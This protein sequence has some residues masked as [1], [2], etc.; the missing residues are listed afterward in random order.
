MSADF[1]TK[2]PAFNVV[3]KVSENVWTYLIKFAFYGLFPLHNRT[4]VIRIPPRAA[5]IDGE[6]KTEPP[7]GS[8]VLINPS[9]PDQSIIKQLKKLELD[10]NSDV[11]YL[12]S[13][14][15]WHY[16]FIGHYMKDFPKAKAYIPPGRIPLQ[17]P[18]YEYTLIDM[19]NPLPQ[20]A[21]DLQLL[22]FWGLSDNPGREPFYLPRME[23]VFFHPESK[24]I[25][26][27]DCMYY[28]G[29]RNI[30]NVLAGMGKKQLRFHYQNWKVVADAELCLQT[31]KRM[32][33]W[34]FDRY[35]CIHGGLGNMQVS[36]AKADVAKFVDMF[37]RP[38]KGFRPGKKKPEEQAKAE[39]K[40]PE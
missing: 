12:V 23:F 22:P 15:D 32:L 2:E 38:P 30:T 16:M 21:P 28:F 37:S 1:D 29:T 18:K 24:M 34:D 25:T 40:N 11:E 20:L 14:C 35:I 33:E 17:K 31:T 7:K 9:N 3:H 26:S 5:S 39:G 10:T 6:S 4:V 13:P 36:G 8:L 27:G 19:S